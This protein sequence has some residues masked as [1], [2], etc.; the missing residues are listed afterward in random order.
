MFYCIT[1]TVGKSHWVYLRQTP[2]C[3]V[4]GGRE[5]ETDRGKVIGFG[6]KWAT[7]PHPSMSRYLTHPFTALLTGS[8]QDM[9][10]YIKHVENPGGYT[11]QTGGSASSEGHHLHLQRIYPG[12]KVPWLQD[13]KQVCK[14]LGQCQSCS[15]TRREHWLKHWLNKSLGSYL[16]FFFF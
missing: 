7:S 4:W 10:F 5:G 11:N 13:T 3:G 12:I 15:Q 6:I 14:Y 8:G 9:W 16:F 2:G 1:G